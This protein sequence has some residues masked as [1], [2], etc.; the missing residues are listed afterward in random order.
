[1]P[2]SNRIRFAILMWAVLGLA[3][4]ALLAADDRV[5]A[6]DNSPRVTK[7]SNDDVR[8]VKNDDEWALVDTRVTDAFN[9]WALDGVRRGGHIPDAVDFPSSWIDIDH[10]GVT[11][12]L[13]AALGTKGIER[14]KH[15][16]LYSTNE[17][18]RR[19]V[20]AYLWKEGFRKLYSFDLRD[21][22]ADPNRPLTRYKNFQLLVPASIAKRLLEGHLPETFAGAKR[23]KFVEVSWGGEDVSYSQGHLPGSFHVNTDHFEP[24]PQWKLGNP[25]VL[26]RFATRYGFQVD[27]TLVISGKDPT[28]CYRLAI[29]LQYMGVG[30]V[31][32]LNGGFAA[33][34]AAG[35][36]V[37]TKSHPPPKATS[38]G[39]RIP[40]RPAL[41]DDLTRV[42]TGLGKPN[43]FM[44]VDTR[45]W[46]E[47]IGNTSGYKYH[48]RKGRIPGSTYGQ[49]GFTGANSLTPY[50]NIDNT[51]RNA[52]EILALWKQAGIS[53]DKHL[54]F[55]CG[56]GWRAAEVLTFARVIG[57]PNTSLYSDGWIG[58]SNDKAN[59]IESGAT[60]KTP[61]ANRSIGVKP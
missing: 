59:P 26:A 45:T 14:D 33:W 57:L 1:M 36:P 51:M 49:A 50:R 16:V 15:I 5:S 9:G 44:L 6:E 53:T 22:A 17:R 27:D 24:P 30:D 46:A 48:F 39:A 58:W 31:R 56:G 40:G 41:I 28:A 52:D 37:E 32:V 47:F 3:V 21:W 4:S 54:S 13:A 18:D 20:A 12:K 23:V 2:S 38:F 19:R 34:N 35:Y 10:E 61:K 29:V 11:E 60:L 7:L 8:R 42:K 25:D 55:M 43:N